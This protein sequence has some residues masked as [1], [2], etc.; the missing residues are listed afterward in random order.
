MRQKLIL[1]QSTGIDQEYLGD[2]IA[3]HCGLVWKQLHIVL[4]RGI[5]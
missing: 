4:E 2:K 5:E 1:A 3:A